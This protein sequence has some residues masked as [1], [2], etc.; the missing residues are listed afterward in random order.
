MVRRPKTPSEDFNVGYEVG[1]TG[2]AK[3]RDIEFDKLK[4]L[5]ALLEVRCS[6]A[7]TRAEAAEKK[8]AK[9]QGRRGASK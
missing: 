8:L 9:G 1:W 5:A 2:R 7:V 6:Q 3:Q 4:A